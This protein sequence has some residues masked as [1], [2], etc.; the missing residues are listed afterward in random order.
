[1]NVSVIETD[2]NPFRGQSTSTSPRALKINP[3][4]PEELTVHLLGGADN[5]TGW[6]LAPPMRLESWQPKYKNGRYSAQIFNTGFV[7]AMHVRAM[8]SM[9][10]LTLM[11]ALALVTTVAAAPRPVTDVRPTINVVDSA[12]LLSAFADEL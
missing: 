10:G 4:P 7:I 2:S 8:Q 5:Q 9:S 6:S 3:H 12:I 1:M 11:V